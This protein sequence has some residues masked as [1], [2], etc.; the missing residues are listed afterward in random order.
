MKG[1]LCFSKKNKTVRPVFNAFGSLLCWHLQMQWNE[2]KRIN[3][4]LARLP[5]LCW[6]RFLVLQKAKLTRTGKDG[7]ATKIQKVFSLEDS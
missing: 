5:K 7:A 6:K 3:L 1:D 2:R 4:A